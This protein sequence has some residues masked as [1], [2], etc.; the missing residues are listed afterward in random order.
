MPKNAQLYNINGKF[1]F[2]ILHSLAGAIA[3]CAFSMLQKFLIGVDITAPENFVIPSIFG[4]VSF[5]IIG[6]LV[7][8]NRALMDEQ[9]RNERKRA[10]DLDQLL[11]EKTDQLQQE[12][13]QRLSAIE[14]L[15]R[16][17]II[18]N[19]LFD[20]IDD[21]VFLKD[22]EKRYLVANRA[23][24]EVSG[25]DSQKLI[26]HTAC[27]VYD[28]A[29]AAFIDE[30]DQRVLNGER[31]NR[32]VELVVRG[33]PRIHHFVKSPAFDETGA[34][35][36]ICGVVRDVTDRAHNREIQVLSDWALNSSRD[37]I[38]I[39]DR[40]LRYRKVNA[41]V[42]ERL[43]LPLNEIEGRGFTEI[44]GADI[45]TAF[46]P[47]FESCLNGT[48]TEQAD[49]VD[50]SDGK[51]RYIIARYD[52][53]KDKD[54]AIVGILSTTVDQTDRKLAENALAESE[55][56]LREIIDHSRDGFFRV[57]L[58]GRLQMASPAMW[59]LLGGTEADLGSLLT[60]F[61]VDSRAFERMFR[62]LSKVDNPGN[63][64]DLQVRHR[65]G[66]DRWISVNVRFRRGASGGVIGIE[67]MARDITVQ[68]RAQEAL[69][70]ER[71]K[72]S[73]LFDHL[74]DSV[75]IH[76]FGTLFL[77]VNAA[78][79]RLLRRDRADL[80]RSTVM[81]IVPPESTVD[82]PSIV[83]QLRDNGEWTFEFWFMDSAGSRIPV[84]VHSRV[85]DYEGAPAVLSVVREIAD[86][87]RLE[88]QRRAVERLQVKIALSSTVA[89]RINNLLTPALLLLQSMVDEIGN[90]RSDWHQNLVEIL[91]T[92]NRIAQLASELV[93]AHG[94]SIVAPAP[95]S[96]RRLIEEV[97]AKFG[98]IDFGDLED[99]GA[100]AIR[101]ETVGDG[102]FRAHWRNRC[103]P[104]GFAGGRTRRVDCEGVAG[105][106][107][108]S[109]RKNYPLS[110]HRRPV[111]IW[112]IL[113][114]LKYLG[115]RRRA[116][117]PHMASL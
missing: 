113:R 114:E 64:F 115:R 2:I 68:R 23:A 3:L 102:S 70:R 65:D 37:G 27:Q 38:A 108:R 22:R 44:F 117:R 93:Q 81:D 11:A 29:V 71:G 57:D 83:A 105:A 14:N 31:V 43:G 40:S 39:L 75:F 63:I 13:E 20:H 84:E 99:V 76:R 85:I 46:L 24:K 110:C 88:E 72:F 96:L 58:D 101:G 77:E 55:S 66:A 62:S 92:Q 116:F 5:G 47:L 16:S 15:R 90:E 89:D 17:A 91:S 94:G 4:A 30:D 87:K 78:A 52:P 12:I 60:Q 106:K 25:V 28:L 10:H 48:T 18:L 1:L 26:G 19:E 61:L 100:V 80:L 98:G 54:D 82:V 104:A 74:S 67:G 21:F 109:L 8:R 32:E 95:V 73:A 111:P 6:W 7:E 112:A 79:C 50:Y 35:V 86:R 45:A 107:T 33:N 51:R 36:G 53:I 41:A 49:W 69:Q 97:A 34:I 103:I 42:A 56:G 9:V 59:K